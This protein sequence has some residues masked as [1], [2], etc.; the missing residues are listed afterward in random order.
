MEKEKGEVKLKRNVFVFSVVALINIVLAL[1]LY[2]SP[3]GDFVIADIVKLGIGYIFSLVT[4]WF[5]YFIFSIK[6]S[7]NEKPI[8]HIFY[9]A[10]LP[11]TIVVSALNVKNQP[12][13]FFPMMYMVSLFGVSLYWEFLKTNDS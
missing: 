9:L 6:F 8:S 10:I 3:S 7:S 4:Y 1:L 11:I 2:F 12:I 5:F 13:L